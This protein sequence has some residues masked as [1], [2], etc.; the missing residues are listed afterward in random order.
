[1]NPV[2]IVDCV[3]YVHKYKHVHANTHT[4]HT[5]YQQQTK[6]F[7]FHTDESDPGQSD[8]ELKRGVMPNVDLF[9]QHVEQTRNFHYNAEG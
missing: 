2:Y 1:M 7:D 4:L 8:R 9:T 3:I 6:T 5:L